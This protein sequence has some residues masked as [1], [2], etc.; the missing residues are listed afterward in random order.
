M[1]KH[2]YYPVVD[3]YYFTQTLQSILQKQMLKIG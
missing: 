3:N 2:E 1:H